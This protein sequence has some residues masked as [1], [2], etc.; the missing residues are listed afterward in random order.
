M[1]FRGAIPGELISD[2]RVII[3]H[4]IVK[5]NLSMCQS[6][7]SSTLPLDRHP[8]VRTRCVT[9]QWYDHVTSGGNTRCEGRT[10]ECGRRHTRKGTDENPLWLTAR[11]Y[12]RNERSQWRRTT[13]YTTRRVSPTTI[14]RVTVGTKFQDFLEGSGH[15]VLDL[16]RHCS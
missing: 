4:S 3:V 11:T 8:Q 15:P 2:G 7:T 14:S 5:K 1:T 13:T 10:Q 9:R 16:R 12:L 6:F